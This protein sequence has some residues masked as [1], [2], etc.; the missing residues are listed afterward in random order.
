MLPKDEKSRKILLHNLVVI[1]GFSLSKRAKQLKIAKST[2]NL[3]IYNYLVLL[4]IRKTERSRKNSTLETR[5][6]WRTSVL[7]CSKIQASV[8]KIW[9]ETATN[10]DR[11]YGKLN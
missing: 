6:K 10:L 2:I 1:P 4:S 5:N 11:V 7:P 3:V 8:F 9:P